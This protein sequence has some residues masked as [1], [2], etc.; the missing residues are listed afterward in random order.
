MTMNWHFCALSVAFAGLLASQQSRADPAP[1]PDSL[2]KQDQASSGSTDVAT[3]GFETAQKPPDAKDATEAQIAAGGLSSEGNSRSIA[4]TASGKFRVRRGSDQVSAAAAANYARAAATKA[5]GLTT[6]VENF[7]GKVRYDRF[8]AGSFAIFGGAS[9][10]RDRFQGLDLRLNLD[11]GIEYY[12]VDQSAQQLGT[13]IGYDFQYDIRNSEEIASAEQT[14]VLLGKTETRNSTRVFVGY[15]NNISKAVTFA[16]GIEYLQGL[17]ETT[18]Y[19]INWDG[20]VNSTVGN[21]FS[22]ATT[23]GVR[24]DHNPLPGV[25]KT[26]IVTSLSLVYHLL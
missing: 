9:A 10:R 2:L 17:A 3:T 22:I 24:Y 14:G 6:T 26:D 11:P 21:G 23:V 12:I 4:A 8:L 19:R 7:Q 15:T 20:S 1:L 13:E 16:S 5:D 18:N 25:E